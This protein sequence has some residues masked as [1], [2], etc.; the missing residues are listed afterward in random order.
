MSAIAVSGLTLSSA[1][2]PQYSIS[3]PVEAGLGELAG[4][5][6]ELLGELEI[7][8]EPRR[9]LG[10]ERRHVERVHHRAADEDNP[11]SARRSAAPRSPA[12]RWSRRRDAASRSR[13][14]GRTGCCSLAGSTGKT[15]SAAPATWP[16]SS[17]AFRSSSTTSPPRA[18]LMMRTPVL[19]LGERLGVDDVARRVG[20]RRVQRDEIGAREE[21]VELDLLDA[22]ASARA[23]PTGTDRRRPPSS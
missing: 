16:L 19:R 12:P 3:T 15:S 17:A 23:R 4:E 18:Q 9:L 14:R 10:R 8:L 22:R 13:R 6:A 21:L 5:A 20:Q 7:G 11:T 1:A 2:W